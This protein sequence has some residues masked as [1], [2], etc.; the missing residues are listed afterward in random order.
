M[1]QGE[2]NSKYKSPQEGACLERIE[3]GEEKAEGSASSGG[4]WITDDL[5]GTVPLTNMKAIGGMVLSRE[6]DVTE[7]C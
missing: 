3:H 7:E 4:T 6:A 1:S 5:M 2:E